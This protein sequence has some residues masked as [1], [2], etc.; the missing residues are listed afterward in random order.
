[1]YNTAS[2]NDFVIHVKAPCQEAL[3]KS[4][5][6]SGTG[7]PTYVFRNKSMNRVKSLIGIAVE[8]A[9]LLCTMYICTTAH[10]ERLCM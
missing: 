4:G 8:Y 2:R 7:I 5:I 9:Q 6:S 1:M 10:F 3:I